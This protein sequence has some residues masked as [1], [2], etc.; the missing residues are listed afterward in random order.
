[1]R[2]GY[3]DP[4][5]VGEITER[6]TRRFGPEV[7]P[8]CGEVPVLAERAA[9]RWGLVLGDVLPAGNSAVTLRCACPDGA[10]A[11]LKLSPDHRFMAEQV[12]MLRLFAPTGRVPAVLD[13]DLDSGVV[14]MEAIEPGTTAA[15]LPR[16]PSARQWADMLT[17]L[18]AVSPPDDQVP[19]LRCEG[20]L[21]R[22]GRRVAEPAIGARVRPADLDRATRRCDALLTTQ[23]SRVLLHGDLHLRNVLDGGQR[24]LVAIDPIVS[25]GD[26]CF[27]AVD[28]V[29]DGAGR[30]GVASR[31]EALGRACGLDV[32]RLHGWAAA[33]AA[34]V[35]IIRIGAGAPEPEVD[36]LLTLAS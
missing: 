2:V 34:V 12:A 21:T 1:V 9:S 20:F 17:A 18:H 23:T 3:G 28:Y 25:V 14:V 19:D 4:V 11:V 33:V 5:D 31:C 36:E 10:A 16:S 35:A 32:D 6:L 26:P 29:L 13:A 15:E 7:A 27:D 8:W 30:D 22:I 24:G